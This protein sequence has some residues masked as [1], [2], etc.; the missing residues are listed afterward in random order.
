MYVI[1]Q[2]Y[3]QHSKCSRGIN[4]ICVRVYEYGVVVEVAE[5]E[6]GDLDKD[7]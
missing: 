5:M 4:G 6:G 7:S 3:H 2:D 1:Y